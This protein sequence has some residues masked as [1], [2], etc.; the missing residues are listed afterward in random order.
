[1]EPQS[2]SK[3]GPGMVMA[4]GVFIAHAL[5]A[6]GV[7]VQELA[8]LRDQVRATVEA[9]GDLVQGLA[10]LDK[11]IGERGGEAGAKSLASTSGTGEP[12]AAS[13]IGLPRRFL[14]QVLGLSLPDEAVQ[15]IE[16]RLADVALEEIAKIDNSRELVATPLSEVKA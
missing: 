5:K 11:A 9:Q 7:T 8:I 3:I 16:K 10:D 6:K 13:G 12:A 15:A 14:L 4:Y 1:M 2:G